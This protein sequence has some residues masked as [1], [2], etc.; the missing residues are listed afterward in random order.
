MEWSDPRRRVEAEYYWREDP[1]ANSHHA[2]YHR[3]SG[4]GGGNWG[5]YFY[6]MHGQMQARYECER[7]SL[8]LG[9]VFPLGPNL[10]R[11]QLRDDYNPRLGQGWATRRPGWLANVGLLEQQRDQARQQAWSSRASY[12]SGQDFGINRLGVTVEQGVHNSGHTQ[13]SQLSAPGRGVMSEPMVA[14]RDTVFFRWHAYVDGLFKEYKN[15]L[16]RYSEADLSF[17]GLSG[18]AVTAVPDWGD[19]NTFYTYRWD[20]VE[21]NLNL[22]VLHLLKS[23]CRESASV[24]LDSLDG[25]RMGTRFDLNYDRLNHRPFNWVFELNS[26]LLYATHSVVRLFLQPPGS[27][28]MNRATFQLDHFYHHLQPGRNVFTRPELSAPHLS[29]SRW[30]LAE[31]QEGLMSGQLDWQQFSWGGCGWPRHLNIPRGRPGGMAWQL[32]AVVSSLLPA[33]LSRLANWRANSQVAWSFCGARWG[34]VPD[35]RP[36]GFPLDRDPPAGDVSSLAAGRPN[37]LILPVTITHLPTG[38]Y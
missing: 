12:Q 36:L 3:L 30:S 19:N 33:D 7:L 32:V 17:P 28:G 26:T 38:Q 34:A 16:P 31:L 2:E 24:G 4:R 35:S 5:E 11:Q 37:W 18:L 22:Y 14:M 10:W 6:F 13:L 8:G 9:L 21:L 25:T 1:V 27:A 20:G 15:W 23:F 29:K